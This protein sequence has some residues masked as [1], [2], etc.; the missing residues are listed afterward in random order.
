MNP[1]IPETFAQAVVRGFAVLRPTLVADLPVR[2]GI[3]ADYLASVHDGRADLSDEQVDL[4]EQV[5]G[6]SA[7]Q[8]AA[9][10]TPRGDGELGELFEKVVASDAA[11]FR[12][13]DSS[14]ALAEQND[15]LVHAAGGQSRS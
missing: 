14:S 6:L 5:A 4:V 8:L 11:C 2:T 15:Q 3:S 13:F 12:A 1:P 10:V 7:L 9:A